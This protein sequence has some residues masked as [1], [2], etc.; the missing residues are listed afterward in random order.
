MVNVFPD[1]ALCH[2][3]LMKICNQKTIILANRNSRKTA[4]ISH[5]V[6]LDV[7]LFN[8]T[9]CS[10]CCSGISHQMIDQRC[11]GMSRQWFS[12]PCSKHFR[13]FFNDYRAENKILQKSGKENNTEWFSISALKLAN[14]KR[15]VWC[16]EKLSPTLEII[17]Q[18]KKVES[19]ENA[20]KKELLLAGNYEREH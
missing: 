2:S 9:R 14:Q 20:Q 4:F 19:N 3:L 17:K 15:K 10:R 1:A 16:A 13:Q 11:L 7:R 18:I 12:D 6:V 8:G 5:L